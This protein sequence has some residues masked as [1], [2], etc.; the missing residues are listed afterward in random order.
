MMSWALSKSGKY[1]PNFPPA[2]KPMDF[3]SLVDN[4]TLESSSAPS[5]MSN[6]SGISKTS[7]FPNLVACLGPK[8]YLKLLAGCLRRSDSPCSRSHLVSRYTA[9]ASD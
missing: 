4:L 7:A 9:C 1:P 5:G 3:R 6:T 8:A 2:A